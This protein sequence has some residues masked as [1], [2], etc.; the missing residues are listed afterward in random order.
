MCHTFENYYDR[1][2]PY[3]ATYTIIIITQRPSNPFFWTK[4]QKFPL[5][6]LFWQ[7]LSGAPVTT[8]KTKC[9][10]YS[11]ELSKMCVLAGFMKYYKKDN[12]ICSATNCSGDNILVYSSAFKNYNL[13]KFSVNWD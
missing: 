2:M 9:N 4:F 3:G 6:D 10:Q 1:P 7:S 11:F 5:D 12:K 8:M 13:E